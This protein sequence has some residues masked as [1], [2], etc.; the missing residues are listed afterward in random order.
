MSTE[1]RIFRCAACQESFTTTKTR[2]ELVKEFDEAFG[3]SPP[4]DAQEI[5]EI[6]DV[7]YQ[8]VRDFRDRLR[9]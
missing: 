6:C 7:C 8:K 3:V 2:A 5:A 1:P 9:N 4:G